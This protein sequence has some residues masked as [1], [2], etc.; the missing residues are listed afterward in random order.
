MRDTLPLIVV[1]VTWHFM[2]C[3]MRTLL[4][5]HAARNSERS[6]ILR[7]LVFELRLTVFKLRIELLL[8][9]ISSL[10]FVSNT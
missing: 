5:K 6:C 4:E 10:K 2:F 7:K 8:Q 3:C 1:L 9:R